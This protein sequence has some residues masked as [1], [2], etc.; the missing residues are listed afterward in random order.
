M[1]IKIPPNDTSTTGSRP[2][3]WEEEGYAS[4]KNIYLCAFFPYAHLL[5]IVLNPHEE[6]SQKQYLTITCYLLFT[7]KYN[8]MKLATLQNDLTRTRNDCT[9]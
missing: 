3:Q 5:I 6:K 4:T 7:I 9:N 1:N 2:V 8:M